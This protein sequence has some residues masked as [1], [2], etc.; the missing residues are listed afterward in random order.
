MPRVIAFINEK[1]GSAKTTLVANIGAY[2]ALRRGHRVLGIDMDPQG[3]LGRV[4]G[5]PVRAPKR[6][7]ID[8]LLDAALERDPPPGEDFE[9]SARKRPADP[10]NPFPIVSTRVPSFDLIVADKSLGLFPT[11]AGNGDDLTA[12]LQHSLWAPEMA[13]YDW[14]LIDSPPSFGPLTLNVLRAVDEV[15]IPVP[16]TYL[17]VNG[18][19]QLTRTLDM[20]RRRYDRESLRISMVIPTFFR[21]TNLAQELL[22]RL[23]QRFPKEIGQTV[24]GY[25]VRIDEAQSY[26]LSIFE[27]APGSSGA[28]AMAALAEE[29]DLRGNSANGAAP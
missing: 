28:V 15:V 27:Y 2:A 9:A 26:G 5:V 17:G 20:V 10:K 3:H 13:P 7:A 23:K 12:R 18:C 21:R 4:L 8:L 1:G 22:E 29:L 14:I 19:A 16:L 24:V 11:L 6:T 25:H